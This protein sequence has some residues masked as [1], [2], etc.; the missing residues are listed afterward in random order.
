[1]RRYRRRKNKQQKILVISVCIVLLLMT[2]GYAAMQTSIGINAKGNVVKNEIDITDNVVTSGDGLYIDEY[3]T[4]GTRY[5]YK[6][7]NPNNYIEFNDELWRIIAKEADETY[8]IIRNE[9][10]GYRTWDS[11]CSNNWARPANLNTYLNSTYLQTFTVSDNIVSHNWNIG[12]ITL[13][14]NDL[15]DQINDEKETTWNGKVGLI[16]ASEYLRANTNTIQCETFSLNN[17]NY[18]ACKDTN[19]M[20]NNN[21]WWT[22]SSQFTSSIIIVSAVGNLDTMGTSDRCDGGSSNVFPALYLSSDVKI[23]YG[24][25]SENDPY[26]LS[27]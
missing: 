10:I 15:A 27:L 24:N 6:G 21:G 1:M 5:V 4:N 9:S 8:K 26:Q 13:D 23:V 25:G 17:A 7:A 18:E 14:N 19:W 20:Y 22:I 16:T 3:E 11:A 2:A 12:D